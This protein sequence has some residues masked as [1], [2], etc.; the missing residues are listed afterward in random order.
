MYTHVLVGGT[1]FKI[2][3]VLF[4]KRQP[5]SNNPQPICAVP[6]LASSNA[7]SAHERQAVVALI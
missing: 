1:N 7:Q 4:R 2:E 3:F 5:F 6:V